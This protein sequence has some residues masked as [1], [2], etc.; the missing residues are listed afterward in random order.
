MDRAEGTGLG[1]AIVGHVALFALLSLGLVSTAK[2]PP[3]KSEPLDVVLVDKIGF[4]TAVPQPATESPAPAEAP[5]VAQPTP[6]AVRDPAPTPPAPRPEPTPPPPPP[7]APAP[8]PTTPPARSRDVPQTRPTEPRPA[9]RPKPTPEPQPPRREQVSQEDRRRPDNTRSRVERRQPAPATAARQPAP[10]REARQPAQ[11]TRTAG[12]DAPAQQRE[13]PQPARGSR[14]SS[15]M[16]ANLSDSPAGKA[17]APRASAVSA[18]AMQG[19]AAAIK[20]QVQPCYELGALSGTPAMQIVTVMR[21][22]F[23]RDGT[24]TGTPQ[25]TD[26][27]GVDGSNRAYQ[28]Q[29]TDVARRAVLRCSPLRLPAELYE[30]GWEDIEFTFR[31]GELG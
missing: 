14:L 18:L 8:K 19:I 31:P 5:E 21:L 7:P 2:L 20:R 13:T 4:E 10:T 12:R 15:R 30:G 26:Q 25:V 28:Q 23:S 17:T 27:T 22:R 6:E 1:V 3:F 11:P 29:I 24:V 9:P 16:F